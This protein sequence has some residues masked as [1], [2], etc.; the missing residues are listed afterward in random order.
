MAPDVAPREVDY[1][2]IG[3]GLATAACAQTLREEGAEGSILVVGRE[4]DPPYHRPA[5]SKGYLQGNEDREA[6]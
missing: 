6:G 4:L 3:G 1:L 5:L 2:L